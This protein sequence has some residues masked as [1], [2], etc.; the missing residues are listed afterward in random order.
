[1][2]K[3]LQ[4][5]L[6]PCVG[7][8]SQSKCKQWL[9]NGSCPWLPFVDWLTWPERHRKLLGLF[10]KARFTDKFYILYQIDFYHKNNVDCRNHWMLN[11][12][13][14]AKALPSQCQG[15][16]RSFEI[17]TDCAVFLENSSKQIIYLKLS[18]FIFTFQTFDHHEIFDVCALC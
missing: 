10:I 5:S 12:L 3:F 7:T 2:H 13:N 9:E 1:M 14:I 8:L 17:I 6:N 18:N 11:L 15:M 16:S 4:V